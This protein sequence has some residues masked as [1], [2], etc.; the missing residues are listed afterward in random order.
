M[1]CIQLKQPPATSVQ[2]H[3][4]IFKIF[5]FEMN[6]TF[7]V[8]LVRVL[9]LISQFYAVFMNDFVNIISTQAQKYSGWNNVT[10]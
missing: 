4:A 9:F 6:V 7:I 10:R 1:L 2:V 8:A 3:A 5:I